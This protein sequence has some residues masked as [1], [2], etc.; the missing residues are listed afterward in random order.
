MAD[1]NAYEQYQL[2]L[3][4]QER[5]ANGAQPLAF[6]R[7]LA[8]AAD[9]H[10]Q[11]MIAADVFSHTGLGDSTVTQRIQAAGYSL[12]GGWSNGENIA[13]ASLRGAPGYEDEV[14][15][16]H[17]NLMNSPGHRA[18]LLN[19]GFRQVGLG[20]EIGEY[21]GYQAAFITQDFARSGAASYLTGVAFDDRDGDRFYDVGEGLGGLTVTV[22]G[23]G[24]TFSTTTV[25]AGGYNLALPSGTYTVTFSGG[26]F[27]SSS[28]QVTVAGRNM[29]VDLVDPVTGGS[30]PPAGGVAGTTGPDQLV[31]G[32]GADTLSG[33]L[34]DD[35][36]AGGAG[37]SYLRGD[38]GD[39]QITGGGDFDDINGNMGDDTASG[40][41]GGDWVVGGKDQDL[42]SGDGGNDIVYGNLGNDTCDGGIGNDTVRGG[43]NEDILTGGAGDDW[44]SGDRGSDTITGGAGADIFHSSSGAGLD[45]VTDFSRAQGDRVMLDA[46]TSYSVSQS[47][48]DVVVD[49]GGGDRVVLVGV[50][51]ASLT[52]GWIFAG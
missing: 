22:A 48:A 6:D 14:L 5:A 21:Q 39:D 42:L 31:G 12:T 43:Q 16:L 46:G 41:E 30:T 13:W 27:A 18:N 52:D 38:E 17:Q 47:G 50:S 51:M 4:N 45:R 2:E 10:S 15:L 32:A 20:F 7:L 28:Q 8:N 9:A 44:L 34:G 25:S 35:T 37:T 23:A 40:G 11:W 36:I 26:G 29:K 3:I 49:M 19:D 24:G 1:A 33:G